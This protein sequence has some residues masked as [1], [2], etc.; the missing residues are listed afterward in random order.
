MKK[1]VTMCSFGKC[2][3]TLV[4]MLLFAL[5]TSTAV[6]ADMIYGIPTY[7]IPTQTWSMSAFDTADMYFG[8]SVQGD[9]FQNLFGTGRIDLFSV[10]TVESRNRFEF[11]FI[12]PITLQLPDSSWSSSFDNSNG[13]L[14]IMGDI[15]SSGGFNIE[16]TF[17][18]TGIIFGRTD[19]NYYGPITG[20]TFTDV[21]TLTVVPVPSAIILGSLGLTFSGWLLHK[22]R[23]L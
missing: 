14:T 5:S 13:N 6:E 22:R 9:S 8:L 21:D 1:L 4:T 15:P 12:V 2:N 17:D 16:F 10:N 7:T 19:F 20:G 3:I 18:P 23:M 11:G